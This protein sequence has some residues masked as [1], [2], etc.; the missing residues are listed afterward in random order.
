MVAPMMVFAAV[1]LQLA[2]AAGVEL[3]GGYDSTVLNQITQSYDAGGIARAALDLQLGYRGDTA[4]HLL[5]TRAEGYYLSNE[6]RSFTEGDFLLINRYLFHWEPNENTEVGVEGTYSIGRSGLLLGRS[7]STDLMFLPGIAGEYNLRVD[8][9]RAVGERNRFAIAPGIQGRHAVSQP[10]EVPRQNMLAINT[11]L[12]YNRD[13]SDNVTGILAARG[14][15]FLM[16]GF[17]DWVPRVTSYVGVRRRWSEDFTT[18]LNVGIDALRD[19]YDTSEWFV[20]PYAMG[21]LTWRLPNQHLVLGFNGRY[22]YAIVAAARCNVPVA[23]NT[24]CPS[25]EVVAGGTGRVLG[26][27][28]S[29]VFRPGEG[30]WALFSEA[31]GDYGVT[32]NFALRADGTTD[33]SRVVDVG[34]TNISVAAGVRFIASRNF[35]VFAR[36]NFLY[37]HL[38]VARLP[39]LIPEIVRHVAMLGVTASLSNDDSGSTESLIPFEEASAAHGARGAGGGSQQSSGEAGGTAAGDE[40]AFVDPFDVGGDDP[41]QGGGDTSGGGGDNGADSNGAVLPTP[42]GGS[43]PNYLPPGRG[44][45]RSSTQRSTQPATQTS[46]RPAAP[47]GGASPGAPPPAEENSASPEGGSNR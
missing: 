44:S 20:G 1:P 27:D 42:G 7:N 36:Y 31:S 17:I 19:Q 30:H 4:R 22:E 32:S 39:G 14:E 11:L 15:Y 28:L 12:E 47:G 3:A 24:A 26:G 16:D 8:V 18:V 13:F 25:Q 45:T 9:R 35:S 29:A 5:R 37:S 43:Q 46:R 10:L 21:G 33:N 6:G 40:G 41:V 38:D 23:N 2:A 34:N